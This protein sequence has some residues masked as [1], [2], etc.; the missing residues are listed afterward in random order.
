MRITPD[1]RLNFSNTEKIFQQ[2]SYGTLSELK[3]VLELD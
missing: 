1:G 3:R 2:D